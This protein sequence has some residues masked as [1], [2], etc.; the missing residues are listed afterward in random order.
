MKI[1]KLLL[2]LFLLLLSDTFFC[3][4]IPL[5]SVHYQSRFN[6]VS[7]F[8]GSGSVYFTGDSGLIFSDFING[9]P[10]VRI[11]GSGGYFSFTSDLLSGKPRALFMIVY[12]PFTSDYQREV[13]LWS[14]LGSERLRSLTSFYSIEGARRLKYNYFPSSE[15]CITTNYVSFNESVPSASSLL[16]SVDTFYIG[17]CDSLLFRGRLAEFLVIDTSFTEVERQIWQSYLSLKYGATIYRGDYVNSVGDT[18]WHYSRHQ[19]FSSGVGGIGRDDIL[20]LRQNFSRIYGDSVTISLHSYINSEFQSRQTPFFDGEYIFWGHNGSSCEPG[21]DLYS[22]GHNFYNFYQRRWQIQPHLQS[23]RTVDIQINT[24][25]GSLLSASGN[26]SGLKLFVSSDAG[27]NSLYTQ[28]YN[29]SVINARRVTFSDIIIPHT[30]DG[31]FYFTFGYNTDDFSGSGFGF[32]GSQDG[33]I[34]NTSHNPAVDVFTEAS[35][36][37]NPVTDNLY[38]HY[39]LTR[40]ATIWFSVHSNTGVPLS[41]TSAEHRITGFNQSVIPMSHLITGTYTVYIHVDD[42]VL[43][44]T[45]I[46]K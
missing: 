40:D 21:N 19:D 24:G 2:F 23:D 34:H 3:Q 35:Y 25:T 13:G 20:F 29:P 43:M 17:K 45:V 33:V 28:I 15:V 32:D 10:A 26:L 6:S 9:Y 4:S 46:K 8:G 1:I 30:G 37:P 12:Q 31:S 18:L 11:E 22:L 44:Q 5:P 39:T 7:L 41:H 27:F 36:L 38:V 16:S 14:V 42:M